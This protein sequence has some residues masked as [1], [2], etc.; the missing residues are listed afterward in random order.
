MSKLKFDF[1]RE[2]EKHYKDSIITISSLKNIYNSSGDR[3]KPTEDTKK[4]GVYALFYE[5]ELKKI[6]KATYQ[7]GIYHRMVQYYNLNES[8]GLKEITLEN[9][10]SVEVIYFN[11]L[12]SDECWVAERR[13]QVIAHDCKERMPWENKKRN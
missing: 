10:D 2:V 13:L 12:D 5:G 1:K 4:I 8:G 9:R 3:G 11:L 7:D 6:G